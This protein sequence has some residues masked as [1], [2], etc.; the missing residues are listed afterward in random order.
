MKQIIITILTIVFFQLTSHAQFFTNTIIKTRPYQ[1]FVAFNPTL[2]F[3]KPIH[4]IFSIEVELMY[5]NRNWN[6]SGGEWDFGRYYDGDGY[7]IL[8]GSKVYFGKSNR[9]IDSETQKAPFGWFGSVQI[10]YSYAKT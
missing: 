10:A 6:S 4:K 7:R 2:G 1:D 8:F 5:R 3:E 9:H